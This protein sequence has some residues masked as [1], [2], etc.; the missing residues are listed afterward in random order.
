MT[1]QRVSVIIPA[2]NQSR[3][4]GV[5]L[6]SLVDQ[7]YS[8]WIALLI[9]DGSTDETYSVV[10]QCPDPRIHY[11]YQRNQGLSS[12]RNSGL[13]LA[14]TPYVGFLDADDV[15]DPTFLQRT[16]SFLDSHPDIAAI[17]TWYSHIDAENQPLPQSGT[18][19]VSPAKFRDKLLE[20]GFFPPC[21]VIARTAVIRSI[22]AFDT[23]L[24]ALEDWDLWLRLTARY[25]MVQ[26][27]ERLAR[28]RIH[29]QSMSTDP[30]RMHRNRRSV[31]KKQFGQSDTPPDTW[32]PDK[33]KVYAFA[34]RQEALDLLAGGDETRAW[35]SVNQA[36]HYDAK[37]L[38][39]LSTWYE[40]IY[41]DQPRGYRGVIELLNLEARAQNIT[42]H[43]KNL[44]D[45]CKENQPRDAQLAQASAYLALAL[46]YE[47]LGDLG[48]SR[49]YLL[50][51][52][53]A[54]PN[55]SDLLI[56]ARRLPVLAIKE[57]LRSTL[58]TSKHAA[59]SAD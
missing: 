7:T 11:Q 40:L 4:L 2:Y 19:C 53:F 15:W 29:P 16:L 37:I 28:Y 45:Q 41:G 6:K 56:I 18:T 38:H 46:L 13:K 50:H 24:T 21:S 5:T 57:L 43:L 32:S 30:E 58:T 44:V 23:H 33:R 17:H 22:G 9:D 36:R 27:R 48:S 8:D 42:S 34:E 51:S 54:R 59:T 3:F 20:G 12:A 26:L 49:R 1:S 55:P 47:E 14:T 52:I 10:Q 39:T 25:N 31:L 35:Q